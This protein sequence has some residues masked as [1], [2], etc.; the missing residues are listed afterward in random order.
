MNDISSLDFFSVKQTIS[1][2]I[3]GIISYIYIQIKNVYDLLSPTIPKKSQNNY[4]LADCCFIHRGPI[5]FCVTR[6]ERVEMIGEIDEIS[7]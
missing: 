1:S 6:P 3:S 4:L 7:L 2:I 5:G